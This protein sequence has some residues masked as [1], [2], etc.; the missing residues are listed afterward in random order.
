[1]TLHLHLRAPVG[2]AENAL[3]SMQAAQFKYEN[4]TGLGI[5]ATASVCAIPNL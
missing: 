5:T 2:F 3:A 4:Q 1:M